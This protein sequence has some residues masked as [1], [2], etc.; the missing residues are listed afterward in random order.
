MKHSYWIP[1]NRDIR[2]CL[3]SY[4]TE[5][6]Y[7]QNK[8]NI[9]IPVFIL[10]S[11]NLEC[12]KLNRRTVDEFRA[13]YSH[14]TII[15]LPYEKQRYIVE[16]IIE[17][18]GLDRAKYESCFVPQSINYGAVMNKIYLLAA[19]L[20]YDVIHRRDSDTILQE[21][22]PYPLEVE[23]LNIGKVNPCFE[24]KREVAI[25][26]SGY[27]GEWNL[28][29]KEFV[30]GNDQ[31]FRRFLSCLNISE[32][33]HD[34]FMKETYEECERYFKK[35]EFQ[36]VIGKETKMPEAG[37]FAI[38]KIFEEFPCLPADYTLG[39]D[40]FTFKMAI[41]FEYPVLFHERRVFHTYHE[42]RKSAD[43]MKRYVK[44]LAKFCDHSPVYWYFVNQ[45]A[46]P[47]MEELKNSGESVK[48][49]DMDMILDKLSDGMIG[50]KD[51]VCQ[52]RKE[53]IKML[54]LDFLSEKYP[55]DA[56][57]IAQDVDKIIN[58]CKDDYVLHGDLMKN[59][60]RLMK[61]ANRSS[62]LVQEVCDECK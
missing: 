34:D 25:V 37:N 3:Q 52:T 2:K 19:A 47:L 4:I 30:V 32:Q 38:Y 35:D 18:A 21:N 57:N 22:C 23:I 55:I 48:D 6:E 28:D 1:T 61:A 44:S 39:S 40:Y 31:L 9:N 53:N 42:G 58:T 14:V 49:W 8:F 41:A 56:K 46:L 12:E 17:S 24:S 60:K 54:A 26:G 50:L 16:Y 59:W 27:V 7:C 33:A 11:G 29:I 20:Q 51:V 45:V 5:I 13:S 43:N 10:D 36:Y 15:Y 62:E